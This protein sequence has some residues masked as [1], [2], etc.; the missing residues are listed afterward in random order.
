M[1]ADASQK[2]LASKR[3]DQ[4]RALAKLRED[5]ALRSQTHS[6]SHI[7]QLYRAIAGV[8]HLRS[9]SLMHTASPPAFRVDAV[10][11]D[12]QTAT[13]NSSCTG[14]T[15]TC[16][17]QAEDSTWY[18]FNSVSDWICQPCRRDLEVTEAPLVDLEVRG[19]PALT[20]FGDTVWK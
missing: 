12:Q 20:F 4:Q 2:F 1:D 16:T 5:P 15:W 6:Q 7:P 8:S 10:R 3:A 19:V 11:H 18:L 14:P 13:R 17:L 9:I